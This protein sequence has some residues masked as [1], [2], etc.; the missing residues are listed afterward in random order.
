MLLEPKH[1][2][3]LLFAAFLVVSPVQAA[4]VAAKVRQCAERA[5]SPADEQRPEGVAGVGRD[6]MD[7]D[8]AIV[9]CEEALKAFPEDRGTAFN[10][11]RALAVRGKSTDLRRIAGLYKQAADGGYIVGQINYGQACELGLGLAR[12]P[13]EALVYYRKAAEAGHPVAAYNLGLML[14]AGRGTP[15]DNSSAA[16]WYRVAID[17]GYTAAM[18]D[19]GQLYE[20]GLGVPRDEAKARA[21]YEKAAE[22]GEGA[23]F[24]NLGWMVDRGLAGFAL[25]HVKANTYYQ[26]AVD[27]GDP[28]GMNNL[29]E[30]LLIGEGIAADPKAG[31][32]LFQQAYDLGNA[33]AA[34]NLGQFYSNGRHGPPDA[35]RAATYYIE[36]IVRN[37]DAARVDLLERGGADLSPALIAAIYAEM[38]KRGLV[39]T[40]VADRLSQSAIAALRTIIRR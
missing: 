16:K 19:L 6:A 23:A 28:Q 11:G 36:A 35:A 10:L 39:F 26:R 34:R 12:D 40:P 33:M 2:P 7:A 1:S 4:D 37:S 14:D 15:E 13:A 18:I 27:A 17:G 20:R 31:V 24:S 21:L 25:D 30:S 38:T 8:A 32:A 3:L 22:A 9:S 5:S 29:G